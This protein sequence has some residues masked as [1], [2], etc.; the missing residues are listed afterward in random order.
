MLFEEDPLIDQTFFV[1]IVSLPIMIQA[2]LQRLASSRLSSCVSRNQKTLRMPIKSSTADVLF[3]KLDALLHDFDDSDS[4]DDDTEESEFSDKSDTYESKVS[5][6]SDQDDLDVETLLSGLVVSERVL[7][8]IRC[9]TID[10]SQMDFRERE[11]QALQVD[12]REQQPQISSRF[13]PFPIEKKHSVSD[14]SLP[15]LASSRLQSPFDEFDSML[16]SHGLFHQ[17]TSYK[18]V[19]DTFLPLTEDMIQGYD[20]A[21]LGIVRHNDLG[22]LRELHDSGRKLQCSNPFGESIVHIVARRGYREMLDFLV[23]QA[24]V[25]M[26][27]ICDNGRTILHDACW[28][29][30]PNFEMIKFIIKE[31]P[32][33]LFLSDN[34][35]LTPLMYVPKQVWGLW[36]TFLKENADFLELCLVHQKLRG[37]QNSYQ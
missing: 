9:H 13:K 17:A 4:S 24:G 19:Q 3:S 7:D 36:S 8:L 12:G 37:K 18:S 32:D 26:R 22:S 34:R 6:T 33:F 29:V 23:Q 1:T 2:I 11:I 21:L 25:S 10:F 5:D 35:N 28:S 30:E 14:Q 31:C 20:A 15:R 16:K 27:V